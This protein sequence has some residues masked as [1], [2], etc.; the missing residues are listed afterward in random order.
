[1]LYHETARDENELFR[2][3]FDEAELEAMKTACSFAQAEEDE[4]LTDAASGNMEEFILQMSLANDYLLAG[5]LVA[6]FKPGQ[7]VLIKK[8]DLDPI[9]KSLVRYRCDASAAQT[10]VIDAALKKIDEQVNVKS[11]KKTPGL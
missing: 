11:V 5:K 9:R 10:P 3:R 6:Y 7:D 4:R 8:A 2:L 1:M